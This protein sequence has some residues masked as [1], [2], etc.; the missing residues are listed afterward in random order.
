MS[1]R[2][3]GSAKSC[4]VFI[5]L[6]TLLAC[7]GGS[8]TK[9]LYVVGAGTPEVAQFTVSSSGILTFA[10]PT[11]V[12][13]AP[14]G[15]FITPDGRYA[16]VLAS[17][18]GSPAGAI[19]QFTLNRASGLLTA[20]TESTAVSP[21]TGTGIP[22]PPMPV[23]ATPVSIAGDSN[24]KFVFVANQGDNTIAVFTIDRSTGALAE[25]NAP[26]CA[27]GAICR[28]PITGATG[29][30]ALAVRGNKLFVANLTGGISVF[31][32]DAKS[33]VLTQVSGSPFAADTNF[34]SPSTDVTTGGFIPCSIDANP[35]GTFLFV[36]NK[37]ANA[38]VELGVQ[39]SGALTV[40][41]S[42][43]TGVMPVAV[44]VHR[45]GKFVYVANWGTGDISIFA[46]DAGGAL[47]PA[48]GSPF[49]SGANPAF[50]LNDS[51]GKLMFVANAGDGTVSAFAVNGSTG[52]LA[53]A[54]G[55]PFQAVGSAMGM[56]TIN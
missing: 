43:A 23:G 11:A 4:I 38:I 37:A 31:T 27:T 45:S 32:F 22:V 25:V 10:K 20:Q 33:G 36:P 24:S 26:G 48:L 47:T 41:N 9:T 14:L 52:V 3:A 15:M 35:D 7:G 34:C 12:G 1:F 39:P 53:P 46:A 13:A 40:V 28:F 54:S 44:R 21:T 6:A 51:S 29:P 56:A 19:S 30:S 50:I 2:I 8:G 49:P 16:Y 5:L 17:A 55:S 42:F 18:M